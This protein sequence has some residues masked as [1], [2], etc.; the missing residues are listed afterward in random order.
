MSSVAVAIVM[1]TK[2]PTDGRGCFRLAQRAIASD[3]PRSEDPELIIRQVR[4]GATAG[5]CIADRRQAIR[6]AILEADAN[7]VILIAG[8]GH[9]TYQEVRGERHHFS[10]AEEAA[11]ALDAW[12]KKQGA[13][14]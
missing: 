7:D 4:E 5:E 14:R 8:K 6:N 10:D 11:E 3:N 2:A 9:E 12:R 1:Q 13:G